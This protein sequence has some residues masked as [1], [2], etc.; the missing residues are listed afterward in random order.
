MPIQILPIQL[1]NQIAA[2]EVVERP[3]SVVKELVE[4]SLDAGATDIKIDIEKGGAKRIRI[5]DNG[6][7]IVK[8]ELALALSR[9][10]TSKIKNLDDLEGIASLGFRGEALA[11]ISSV[12]RLVLTSKPAEQS[13]AWQAYAEGSEMVVKLQPAAQG[14]GTTVD[15]V[16]LFF[17]TPARR[18]FLR[19]EKTEFAHIDEVVKR[20][21][22]A[23]FDVS[24]TLSHN[25]K[26]VRQY[27]RITDK[28]HYHRRVAQICGQRFIEQALVVDCEH[29][30]LSLFG[31]IAH[32][33]FTRPQNDLCYSYVNGRMMRDKLI[34]HAIRQAYADLIDN[35]QYPA[36][37]LFLTL[38]A[39]EVDVNV[40]PAKHEVR[41]H[42]AR[43][44]HD[45]IVSVIQ[46]AL[47]SELADSQMA[48]ECQ[49]TT[50]EQAI[51]AAELQVE[52][53]KRPLQSTTES[54][55]QPARF[56]PQHRQTSM[57]INET[58]VQNYQR[59]M[60]VSPELTSNTNH[61]TR[62]LQEAI[63]KT[64][65]TSLASCQWV[66]FEPPKFA[67]IKWNQQ[68]KLVN[69]I[70]LQ[71][72]VFAQ[73]LAKKWPEP[74]V[75]QPLLLPLKLTLS[76]EETERLVAAQPLI[77][78]LGFTIDVIDKT[79]VVVRKIAQLLRPFE[80]NSLINRLL[81]LLSS[82]DYNFTDELSQ[83]T[84][85]LRRLADVEL[86]QEVQAKNVFQQASHILGEDFLAIITLNSTV[87]DLTSA[88]ASLT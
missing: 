77:K 85:I 37:V 17:N 74:L 76:I 28:Q 57:R 67:V 38:D 53:L 44:V 32:P 3:A 50:P 45:F 16:D 15:I 64:E 48:E 82:S 35:E 60:Q 61:K 14:N 69:L 73:S 11:S 6:C 21:A 40:H 63:D 36:F 56:A 75:A 9:H 71:Q 72:A 88:K 25:G 22:L 39:R 80:V 81:T 42:Q 52:Q 41:F 26:V 87:I 46:Q 20:I 30:G 83:A 5:I 13:M 51:R 34:N 78:Q 68:L 29:Q 55:Y 24:F 33:T 31:W 79:H 62:E 70:P 23:K 12:S 47:A 84:E 10:A 8:D 86:N 7:G 49:V 4:N 66:Q 58:A 43:Y 1:A 54:E 18:K 27:R 2:G 65:S 19:T 59:L